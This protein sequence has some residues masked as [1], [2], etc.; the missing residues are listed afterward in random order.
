MY[1]EQ[2]EEHAILANLQ[3]RCSRYFYSSCKDCLLDLC[4]PCKLRYMLMSWKDA[5]D[6][7]IAGGSD[8][9]RLNRE[10]REEDQRTS[11]EYWEMSGVSPGCWEIPPDEDCITSGSESENEKLVDGSN[12]NPA[13]GAP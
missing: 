12:Y 13:P 6:W 11:R 5:V 9:A 7:A 4:E 3:P 8:N 2:P 1:R 10:N